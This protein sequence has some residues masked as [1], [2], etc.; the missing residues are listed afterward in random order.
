MG[1]QTRTPVVELRGECLK[2]GSASWVA[3]C[4]SIRHAL[5]EHGFFIAEYD[6]VPLQLH[7]HI[8]SDTEQ[9]FQ[10]PYDTKIKNTSDK[11]AHGYIGK[12][13]AQ[14]LHEGLGIDN[15]TDIESCNNF[16]NI[17]WPDSGNHRFRWSKFQPFLEKE[18]LNCL[19]ISFY[20]SNNDSKNAHQYAEVMSELVQTVTRMLFESYSLG[21][22]HCD[23]H[24]ESASYLLRYLCYRKPDNEED[25][26]AFVTHTDKSFISILHQN[27][28]RGLELQMGDGNWVGFEPSPTSFVVL[29]GDAC[30][31]G[32]LVLLFSILLNTLVSSASKPRYLNHCFSYH[33]SLL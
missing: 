15:A 21:K 28:V 5:E 24:V 9:L 2:Q 30:M 33:R 20:F 31:V 25:K 32:N 3:A 18:K 22:E 12:I 19:R 7:E 16:S 4:T 1:S 23:S 14:S 17:L 10:L 26:V 27:H 6:G 11:P 8:L 29:A 13:A